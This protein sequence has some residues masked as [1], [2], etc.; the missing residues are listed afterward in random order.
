MYRNIIQNYRPVI[1]LSAFSK[2]FENIMYHK[3]MSFLDMKKILYKHQYGFRPNHSTIYPIMHLLNHCAEATSE[4]TPEYTL[5]ALCDLSKAFDVIDHEILIRKLNI[6][7][8]RGTANDWLRSY[9]S[10]RVQYV[11]FYENIS[12]TLLMKVGVPQ[13]SILGRLLI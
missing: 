9:L 8:I 3:I 1:L 10:N 13:G 11:N 4:L 2:I 5:V 6:Y 12:S 7:G